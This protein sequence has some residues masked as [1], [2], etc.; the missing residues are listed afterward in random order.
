MSAFGAEVF[1]APT[2]AHGAIGPGGGGVHDNL[3]AAVDL[4]HDLAQRQVAFGFAEHWHF[5]GQRDADA[6]DTGRD[7]EVDFALQHLDV[8]LSG[9]IERHRQDRV[10]A[11]QRIA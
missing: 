1:G 3:H 6:I 4:T 8:N 2:V 11:T 9:R 10:D 5:A 7:H